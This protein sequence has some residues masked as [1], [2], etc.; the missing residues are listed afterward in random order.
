MTQ[1][2]KFLSKGQTGFD[3]GADAIRHQLKTMPSKPGVYRMLAE[4]GAVLY[5]GKAKNLKKR[6]ASYTQRAR[7]P[8]RLQRMVAQTRNMEIMVTRTEAEALL[9]EADFIQRF[10]PPF[11]VLLRDDKSYPYILITRDHDFPRIA[12]HRGAQ[13]H[14][15]WY[16]GPFASGSAVNETINLL[17]RGFMIRSCADNV[18][19]ARSRPCL[20]YHIK[21]CTAPCVKKVS[22]SRYAEQVSDACAFLRGKNREIQEKLKEE[23]LDASQAR[24]FE[25]AA[26]LRDRIKVLTSIQSYQETNLAGISDADVIAAHQAAGQTAIQIFF[27]RGNRG[28]GSKTHILS[29]DKQIDI[30]EALGSFIGQFYIDKI[31]PPVV[32]ISHAPEDLAVIEKALSSRAGHKVSIIRP[33]SGAKKNLVANTEQN[34]KAALSR[35]MADGSAQAALLKKVAEIFNLPSPPKRIEVYDNSH[36]GGTNAVGA[37]IAAGP[38]GFLKKT[39]RKFNIRQAHGDDDF[40]MMREVLTR[41]FERLK[42]EDPERMSGN[43]PDLLLIDGGL[44]QLNQVVTILSSLGISDIP[45]VGIAKGPDRNA[46]KERFFL[47]SGKSFS[48]PINDPALYYLQRLR[49]EAHRFAIGTHRAKR[50]KSLIKSR[51]DEIPGIGAMRKREL[52][53]HFGSAKEVEAASVESLSRVKGISRST[54]KKVYDFFHSE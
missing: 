46:G 51:L 10:M 33:T 42:D 5:V 22:K 45:V 27:I 28:Y 41:R 43:W 40:G 50:E 16:F 25:N 29:H 48:L 8:N 31:I 49:D 26:L 6:V 19:T 7:L 17:Q 54:A 44:G 47:Q 38:E 36:T 23:M 30:K 32:L 4:G 53:H 1:T 14:K 12:K 35:K 15:G 21:R 13:K 24:E 9:L 34:A 37:M 52:L 11:N 39:Y 2:S 20:Q 3:I 18:F